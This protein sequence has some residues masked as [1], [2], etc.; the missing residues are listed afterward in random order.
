[1]PGVQKLERSMPVNRGS[2]E[3]VAVCARPACRME[4]SVGVSIGRLGVKGE[5]WDDDEGSGRNLANDPG[6]G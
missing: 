3:R 6:R 5:G 2:K 1:M 4:S